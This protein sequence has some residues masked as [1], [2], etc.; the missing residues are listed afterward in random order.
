MDWE[1]I[2]T[3]GSPIIIAVISSIIAYFKAVKTGNIRIKEV[4][5]QSQIELEKIRES[6]KNE[7]EK[8]QIEMETQAKLYEQNKKTDLVGDAMNG[9]MGDLMKSP[10]VQKKLEEEFKKAF[11]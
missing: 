8:I 9:I 6:H 10:I 2:F 3:I 11:K 5:K 7:L 1:K 4:E